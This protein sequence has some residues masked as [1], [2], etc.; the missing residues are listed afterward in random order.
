MKLPLFIPIQM[1]KK[2]IYSQK[3]L[4]FEKYI[5]NSEKFKEKLNYYCKFIIKLIYIIL[6]DY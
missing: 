5:K 2:D 6:N 3:F 1:F 4:H